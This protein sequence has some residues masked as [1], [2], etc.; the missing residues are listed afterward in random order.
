M[1]TQ[2]FEEEFANS[3]KEAL[4]FHVREHTFGG[5]LYTFLN[6]TDDETELCKQLLN[7]E[8]EE[9]TLFSQ[10]LSSRI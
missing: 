5:Y 7:E 10:V 3:F 9:H 6:S 2:S 4:E 8:V 1:E